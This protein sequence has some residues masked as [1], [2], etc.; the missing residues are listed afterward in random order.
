MLVIL[1]DNPRSLEMLSAALQH[2]GLEILTASRP[3]EALELVRTRKPDLLLT[4]L[5]MPGMDGLEVLDRV[6]EIAPNTEVVLMTA[7]YTT[8]TAVA[9]IRRGA[10]DYLEK[11]VKLPVLR[12]RIARLV[13]AAQ[14]RQE[15]LS[16]HADADSAQFEGIVAA[17]P[18]MWE[19]FSRMRR[20]GPHFRSVLIEGET[21]TGKDLIAAALHRQSGRNGAYVVVN[22]S[23]IVET[24]FESELFG[25]VKGAFTGADRDKIGLFEHANGGTLFLDEVGDMPLATQAKLLRALQ[26]QE[27]LRVGSLVPHK[28]DVRIIA[29]T[30][31]DLR[32]EIARGSFR[33]DLYY[34]LSMITLKVPP[35]RERKEDIPLL[36]RRFLETFRREHRTDV[37]AISQRALLLLQQY[38]WPGNVR[39]LQNAVGHASI[40]ARG[41]TLEIQDLPEDVVAFASRTE[42]LEIARQAIPDEKPNRIDSER[43]SQSSLAETERQLI[44]RAVE[45]AADNQSEAARRLGIGRDAL[46][47]KLKRHGML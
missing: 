46:R 32:S 41:S 8:E 22:G 38:G 2:E 14:L 29:A 28:V 9:A 47:Y 40:M 6:I 12:E 43:T 44:Q 45:E 4:D 36:A 16:G 34:R 30:N 26:N 15:V 13:A 5:V 27:V 3:E 20:I 10:A 39:Q 31:R 7:H 42:E 33:E 24:L 18:R 17:S 11:P 35:L 25:H 19:L 23:A 21:G 37:R 1:D